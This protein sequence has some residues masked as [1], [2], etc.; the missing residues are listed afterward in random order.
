MIKCSV[1]IPAFNSAETIGRTLAALL[2]ATRVPDEIIVVDGYSSDKTVEIAEQFGALVILNE[3]RHVA[4]A[5]QLGTINAKYD[6][7]AF[8]D[9]DC[10]PENDWLER[11]YN[12]FQQDSLLCGTGGKVVLSRPRNDIQHFS[13]QIFETIMQFPQERLFVSE[14]KMQGAF[15]GANCAF[16]RESIINAGGFRDFF[17]N[18]AEE[19]DLFWRLSDMGEKLLFD[20]EI[21]VE[22]LDYADSIKR[23]I[24]AN[25]NYGI[26][27]TK[28]AKFHFGNQIDLKLYK[29][30]LKSIFFAIN[31]FSS[32]K[33]E[34][35]R[36]I[37]IS[38]FITGKI[39]GSIRYKIINL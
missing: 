23:L 4:A 30:L 2:A 15:P 18:H 6:V 11:I 7:V 27:G 33:S 34:I 13:A 37:Q 21:V 35:F 29:V 1:V 31:P 25:F 14:K 10:I 36:V 16:K 24:I 20:P 3:K 26:A 38:S 17:S 5:R 28:L 39:Y 19:I 9:S 22:H 12:N 32:N 8:T